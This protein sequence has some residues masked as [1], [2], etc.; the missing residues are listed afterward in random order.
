MALGSR[1]VGC[2]SEWSKP[3][4]NR[5]PQFES[6]LPRDLQTSEARYRRLFESTKDGILM[7]DADTGR[8]TDANPSVAELLE[9]APPDLLG[10][11]LWEIGLFRDRSS[12]DAAY[13]KLHDE[14]Y[15]HDEGMTLQT[16]SGRRIEVDLVANVYEVDDQK[17][18]QCHIRDMTEHRK[19][20]R[21]LRQSLSLLQATLDSS[22]DGILAVDRSGKI[23]RCN[24]QF[25]QLWRL[26]R[27]VVNS[28]DDG[29]VLELIADQLKAPEAFQEKV[30]ELRG[31][32]NAESFDTWECTDGRIIEGYSKPQEIGGQPSGRVWSFRDVTARK[33]AEENI[34]ELSRAVEQSPVSVVIT[35]PVGNIEYVN[36]K[37]TELTGYD[38][39]EVLGRNPRMLKSGSMPAE[40]YRQLWQAIAA[41]NE[42]RGELHN[43]KKNGELY[44]EKASISAIRDEAGRITHFLAVKEDITQQKQM[45]EQLRQAQKMEAVG[46]LAGGVAHDFNNILTA[47]LVQLGMLLNDPKLTEDVKSSLRQLESEAN[48]AANLTRQLLTFSRQQVIQLQPV[49]LNEVLA[50]QVKMLQRLMGEHISVE[51]AGGSEPRWIEADLRMIEQVVM[52]LCVNARDAMM[53]KGG[54]L[55]VGTSLVEFDADVALANPEARPGSFVC[56]MVADTGQGMDAHTLKHSFEPFFTTKDVGKGMGLGLATVY[57]IAK[58]HK[59]WVEAISQIRHGSEFRVYFPSLAVAAPPIADLITAKAPKGKETILLVEDEQAVR[60]MVAQGLQ[61]FGYRVLE[62]GDGPEAVRIWDEHAM[63]ID[64]LF[65]DMRMPGGMTG[66]DLLQ[67]LQKTRPA[68][69]AVLSSGYSEEILKLDAPFGQRV[70]YL[71]K[72]Y[73]VKTLALTVRECLDHA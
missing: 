44:W 72:P 28:G 58:Q 60:Q 42:W 67:R 17:I 51:F 9:Y 69:R 40:T 46:Q 50:G 39:D 59:G 15:V 6:T 4:M 25:A 7:L 26:P 22:A 18:I 31:H 43:R 12:S 3:C 55:M 21:T 41:G 32:S 23:V 53:P 30:H 37:F 45:E 11:N 68:L 70:T 29:Q 16:K 8:I 10:K 1:A 57:G 2:L 62:A 61:L 24:D 64:L 14:G 54:R 73:D 49:D 20:E 65:T 5:H 38:R 71:P 36:P 52:N 63:E 33:Q 19:V 35:D 56:L 66:I 27:I 47:T 13:Q 48:R 34:R